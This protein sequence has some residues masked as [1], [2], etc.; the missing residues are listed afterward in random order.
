MKLIAR[1]YDLPNAYRVLD[2]MDDAGCDI[3]KVTRDGLDS[4]DFWA[5]TTKWYVTE[6][7]AK[8][9]QRISLFKDNYK[10]RG[11]IWK[12]IFWEYRF[13]DNHPTRILKDWPVRDP[14][15]HLEL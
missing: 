1:V 14:I 2:I 12:R 7:Q 5:I 3:E 10:K 6:E 9:L 15:F 8:D 4:G 13:E 11:R